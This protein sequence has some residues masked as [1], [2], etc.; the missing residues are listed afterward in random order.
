MRSIYWSKEGDFFAVDPKLEA[1]D[2]AEGPPKSAEPL[3]F[4]VEL[5]AGL[6]QRGRFSAGRNPC[7]STPSST[8]AHGGPGEDGSLKG[9]LDLAGLSYTGPSAASAALGMDKLSSGEVV[10][11]AV[12]PSLPRMLLE[13]TT[14]E[15]EFTGP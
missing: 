2:F 9:A 6:A 14:S 13:T 1:G 8:A 15:I 7:G 3:E 11:A 10:R 12:I 4:T 5:P